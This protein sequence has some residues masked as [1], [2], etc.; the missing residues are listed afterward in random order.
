MCVIFP[1][2]LLTMLKCGGFFLMPYVKPALSFLEQA[3][4]LLSRGL[5]ADRAELIQYLSQINYYRL[6]GYLFP[7]KKS[8]E[9]EVYF[10]GTTLKDIQRRYSFDSEVRS[11]IMRAIEKIEVSI[12]RTQLVE[13][14]SLERGPF[15][16]TKKNN[17]KDKEHF[18]K[19][20]FDNLLIYAHDETN[21]KNRDYVVRYKNNYPDEEYL[22]FWI[23]VETMTFSQLNILIGNMH[24]SSRM[25]LARRFNLA[26]TVLGSWLHSLAFIR[27][28]CA[29]HERL[30]NRYIPIPPRIPNEKNI[31][32]FHKP[33]NILD[34]KTRLFSV[35][36]IIQYLLNYIDP[37]NNWGIQLKNLIEKYPDLPI[38]EIG[39]PGNWFDVPYWQ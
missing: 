6:S 9:I 12:L 38:I 23:I 7:F 3:E 18:P 4:L 31:P 39:F 11:L 21:N 5:V 13:Q 2:S 33:I 14:F 36:V 34:H 27:N 30:W 1:P 19:D 8:Q 37:E 22:P 17:F 32:G 16:Y 15:C 26:Y 20:F 29:H 10:E 35:L 28:A 25:K 24:R